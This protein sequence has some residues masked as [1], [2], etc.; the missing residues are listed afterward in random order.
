[1]TETKASRLKALSS[2]VTVPEFN[3]IGRNVPHELNLDDSCRYMVR[4]SA[5]KEDHELFSQAGQFSTYGPIGKKRVP[6]AIEKA[7]H[8][9]DVDQ[10]IVQKYIAAKQWGVAFCFSEK[11]ILVEYS[12]EFE[13]VTSGTVNP[14]TA[15]LPTNCL[16]Y[17]KLEQQLLKIHTQFGPSDIEFVNLDNPQFVQ[18]RPI[19]R[20]IDY[21]ENFVRLKMQL[22][23]LESSSWRE[24]DVCRILAERDSKSQAFSEIYLQAIEEVYATW[25]KTR[26]SVPTKPFVKISEQYFMNHDLEEQIIPGF[27]SILRLS[28]RMSSILRD[29]RKQ[30]LSLLSALQLMQ[31][32]ILVSLA[33]ELLNNKEAMKLREEIR[34]ELEK[35]VPEGR[36]ETDYHSERVLGS[37]IQFDREKS[38]W[39]Q[40]SYRDEPGIVVVEG[41]FDKGPYFRFKDRNQEIPHGVIVVTEHLYPEIGKYISNINGIICKY[42]ALSAHVAILAREYK[43]PLKIQTEIDQYE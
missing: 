41:A 25:L 24:N 19:T 12:S 4:S 33:Y 8:N 21:D 18:V 10:V 30:D 14:F 9:Q 15:L 13:G 26:V 29:I 16:R 23:E 1:M 5:K 34:L 40:I 3:V 32:S 36:L 35:K 22:Q 37:S 27:I 42:G 11:R 6:A 38:V 39:K 43:V 2:I 20:N 7:F 28:F 17:K 31:K